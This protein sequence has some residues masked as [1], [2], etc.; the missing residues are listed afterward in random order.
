MQTIR[1]SAGSAG[2]ACSHDTLLC[3][4]STP[5]SRRSSRFSISPIISQLDTIG[6]AF[7]FG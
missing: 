1:I 4:H 6:G 7:I 5:P 2:Y 3:T